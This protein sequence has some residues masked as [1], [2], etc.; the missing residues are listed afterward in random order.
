MQTNDFLAKLKGVKKTPQGWAA[1][2]PAHEDKRSSLSIKA[3]EKGIVCKCHAGCLVKDIAAGVGLKLA[4]LFYDGKTVQSPRAKVQSPKSPPAKNN[5]GTNAPLGKVATP[6]S[7]A[8]IVAEYDYLDEK[9]T[10]LFQVVRFEPKDFRQRAPDQNARGGWNWK[11]ADV[12]KVLW[13]LPALMA[14]AKDAGEKTVFICEGEKDVLAFE[15]AGCLATCNPGGAGKWLAGYTGA[16]AAFK[17]IVIVADK[18]APGQNHARTVANCL[19]RAGRT[20]C[21]IEVPGDK[22]KDAADFFA[23][24][25]KADTLFDLAQVAPKIQ[26]AQTSPVAV[27]TDGTEL[28]ECVFDLNRQKFFVPASMGHE[29]IPLSD[30]RINVHFKAR[31]YSEFIKD[32]LGVTKLESALQRVVMEKNVSYAG[33]V[34]GYW[35]G[36]CDIDARRCLVTNGPKLL[37]PKKGEWERFRVLTE[38]MFWDDTHSTL[39][40]EL[41]CG[42]LR[43]AIIAL[44]DRTFQP[45]LALVLC[46]KS[47]NG[48]SF[49][50]KLI[51]LIL[52]G[53]FGNPYD[54]MTEKTNFNDDFLGAEHLTI[55]DEAS[56][57]DIKSRTALGQRIKQIVVGGSVRFDGKFVKSLTVRPFFRLSICL[58]DDAQDLMVLPPMEESIKN[59]FL[60]FHL[61]A[62]AFPSDPND[63]EKFRLAIIGELPAFVHWL[64]N[65]FKLPA[66]WHSPRFGVLN[67][68]HPDLL[69]EMEDLHPWKRLLELVDHVKPWQC[70]T[71]AGFEFITGADGECWEGTGQ[72]L[73]EVLRAQAGSRAASVLRGPQGTGMDL[74]SAERKLPGRIGWRKSN[75]HKIW[76]IKKPASDL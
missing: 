69:F 17:R 31:G 15:R 73:E 50:Q 32:A 12:R 62:G 37:D 34:A 11:T 8:R 14:A 63:F 58:N 68:Q 4:D 52:G 72:D 76:I 51:T 38:K 46:G 5:S 26:P 22:N 21:I 6:A 30:T 40:W 60:I 35:P 45:G 48:K 33:P 25:G 67:W 29:W 75:G 43:A 24:G 74:K 55:D 47:D 10:L 7:A 27:A 61:K 66:K 64:L 36:P 18:D 3:G 71:D 49:L 53:R 57:K 19:S 9:G 39:Q 56:S 65:E 1:Q 42:W 20:L 16:L 41:F 23:S 13:R 54:W 70:K 59:K 28:P 2:C 44:R